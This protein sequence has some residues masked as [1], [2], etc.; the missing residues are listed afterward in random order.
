ME[1]VLKA[2]SLMARI[3]II[4]RMGYLNSSK[5]ALTPTVSRSKHR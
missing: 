3:E 1:K 2:D 4:Y 5:L